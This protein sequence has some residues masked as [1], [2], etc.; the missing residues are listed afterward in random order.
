MFTHGAIY[1]TGS[2]QANEWAETNISSA[3]VR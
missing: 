3:V 2:D 1:N